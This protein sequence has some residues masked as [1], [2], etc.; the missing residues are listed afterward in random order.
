MVLKW[1]LFLRI[2]SNALDPG[3]SREPMVRAFFHTLIVRAWVRRCAR[4][5]TLVI[6]IQTSGRFFE[7][8]YVGGKV[9]VTMSTWTKFASTGIN[10]CQRFRI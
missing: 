2:L 5:L 10:F 7:P 4:L 9:R 6:N 1:L 3:T 8:L